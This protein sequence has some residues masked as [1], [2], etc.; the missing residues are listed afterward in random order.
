MPKKVSLDAG[1]FY[2]HYPRI[3]TIVTA[4][5]GTRENAMAV[6]WNSPLSF[7]PPLF[8]V[9]ISPQRFTH[10]LILESREFGVCFLTLD[11]AEKIAAIG[12]S[13]G[14]EIDKFETFHLAK[15][16]AVKTSVPLLRDAYL[17]YECKLV[18]DHTYGDHH[19]FVGQ[20]VAVH[21]EEGILTGDEL[22]DLHKVTPALYMGA[23]RYVGAAPQT[24]RF[25]DR[26][27]FQKK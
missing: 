15:E 13:K 20:V 7:V 23:D 19:W 10:Q 11:K 25:I 5:S 3:T 24:L 4:R 6:A 9:S 27:Q 16:K 21:I 18:A 8:G 22:L 26:Q 2:Q 12:G 17:S 1:K 14:G